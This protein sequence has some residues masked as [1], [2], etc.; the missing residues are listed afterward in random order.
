MPSDSKMPGRLAKILTA[1][2][3]LGGAAIP[4]LAPGRAEAGT[5]PGIASGGANASL[6]PG[7]RQYALNDSELSTVRGGFALPNGIN[8]S[9]GFSQI[10]KLNGILVQSILVPQISNLANPVPVFVVGDTVTVAPGNGPAQRPAGTP[11]GTPTGTVGN[12]PANLAVAV[13][14][15]PGPAQAGNN[16]GGNTGGNKGTEFQVPVASSAITVSTA[17]P[18]PSG[19]GET[20]IQTTLGP[21]GVLSGISNTLSNEVITQATEMRIGLSGLADAVAAAQSMQRIINAATQRFG[22]P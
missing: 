16:T 8:F 15:A 6:L 21:G 3:L 11:S 9:F 20:A 17:V 4:L 7:L 22:A 14:T 5:P 12:S 2:L 18:G 13:I 1:V 10:T 19:Q